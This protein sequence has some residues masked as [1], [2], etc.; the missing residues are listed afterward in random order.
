M[1]LKINEGEVRSDQGFSLRLG[2]EHISY[3]E[4]SYAAAIDITNEQGGR[5]IKLYPSSVF[6]Y[7]PHEMEPMTS[8]KQ[9]QILDRILEALNFLGV[10]YT[11][12]GR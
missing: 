2:L 6:W 5:S 9:N 10:S 7:P 8:E 4:G 12:E 3:K 11:I 1:L